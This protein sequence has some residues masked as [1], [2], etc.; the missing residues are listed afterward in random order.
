MNPFC[1]Y[2]GA[3]IL[4]GQDAVRLGQGMWAHRMCSALVSRPRHME[5][6]ECKKKRS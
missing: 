1:R 5:G 2:C 6:L 4:E 3:P